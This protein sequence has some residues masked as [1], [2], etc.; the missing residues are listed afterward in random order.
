M[1]MTQAFAVLLDDFPVGT[2]R[3]DAR[4][5]CEFSL[6]RSYRDARPRPT[7]GQ[8]FLDDLERVDQVRSGVPPWFANLLPEGALRE[9]IAEQ[10]DVHP[11]RELIYWRCSEKTCPVQ[12]ASGERLAR[13][14]RR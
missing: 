13:R 3:T 10:A 8:Y 12:C 9:L 6:L 4:D 5:G 1:P 14:R 2:L 11:A 7:L